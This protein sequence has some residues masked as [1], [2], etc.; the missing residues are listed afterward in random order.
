[1]QWVIFSDLDGSL[2]NY[3]GYSFEEAKS[4][5][6]KINKWKIPLILTTSKTRAEVE[7]ILDEMGLEEP[8]IVENG[9]AIFFPA[10]YRGW[11]IADGIADQSYNV[12]QLGM[13]YTE[14][15]KFLR[16][17]A[18]RFGIKG[19]GDLSVRE[20]ADL[21]G[22]P[23]GKAKLAKQ[24]EYTEPFL[25]GEKK[26]IEELTRL[27]AKEEIK[28]VR[29]GLFYHFIG[30][31]QDK[32]KA[33]RITKGIIQRHVG[34]KV[35]FVGIGDG[36]NDIPML[37]HVDIPVVIPHAN[38]SFEQVDLPNL[39]R[40]RLPGSRGWNAAVQRILNDVERSRA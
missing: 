20:I 21:T 3:D 19:F 9:A 13:P 4:T 12:I 18:P 37:E 7:R 10:G 6:K 31:H 28:I 25:L 34:G 23:Y 40:A 2:L 36:A 29:G 33:V 24:R 16:K 15:R 35:C 39:I 22:L 8:F 27:A 26:D 5:L 38:G 11:D 30:I 14:I 1:M 32:G 17:V